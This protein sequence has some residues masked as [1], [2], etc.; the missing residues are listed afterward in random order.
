MKYKQSFALKLRNRFPIVAATATLLAVHS[1]QAIAPTNTEDDVINGQTD[2]TLDATYTGGLPGTSSDVTFTAQ[3]YNPATFT[4]PTDLSI[5]TLNDLATNSLTIQAGAGNTSTLTLNGGSNTVGADP[6]DLIYVKNNVAFTVGTTGTTNGTLKLFLANGG[7]IDIAANTTTINSVISD[8]GGGFTKTGAGTLKLTA[9]NTYTGATAINVGTLNLTGSILNSAV[10]VNT[11]ATLLFTSNN[12]ESAFV[13]GGIAGQ[14]GVTFNYGNPS[15]VFTLNEANTYTGTTTFQSRGV[16]KANVATVYS[17][18]AP[19]SGALGVNS[20]LSFVNGSSGE[21]VILNGKSQQVGALIG[22]QSGNGIVLNG[23]NL[24]IGGADESGSFSGQITGGLIPGGATG[25][26]YNGLGSSANVGGNLIKIGS[27]VQTLTNSNFYVGSTTISGG[28]LSISS[29]ADGGFAT[30][31][32]STTASGGTVLNVA[33]PTG[34]TA[35]QNVV[36]SGGIQGQKVSSVSG[37]A[38]TLNG[39]LT[40]QAANSGTAVY[41]GTGNGL[42]ISTNAASNLVLDGGT[43]QYKGTTVGSTDRLFQI[44]QSGDAGAVTATI[45]SSS[46]SSTNTLSFTNTGAVT[47]GNIGQADNL[48]LT[49]SNTGANTLA[50]SIGDNGAGAVSVAKTGVGSWTVTNTNTY[51]GGTTV[52]LGNLSTSSTGT[53]G[54]GNVAV[55]DTAGT[56]L[57]LQNTASIGSSAILS[58]GTN[59]VINMNFTGDDTLAG[60]TDTTTS[61]MITPGTYTA[62]QL[63]SFF[64][65]SSFATSNGDPTSATF[66]VVPEPGTWAMLL[67]G[68]GTL[69][70]FQRARRRKSLLA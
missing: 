48:T 16:V 1:A 24:T 32:T 35:G 37:N 43:L 25:T 17:G 30:T 10:T 68:F 51:T 57:T 9:A 39:G 55:A 66:T 13:T 40:D 41:F 53:L 3:S 20:M 26:H 69:V 47:Y 52:S 36:G 59:S 7:N 5:G 63:D 45:D 60:I 14:G 21:T 18:G 62:A 11:G 28:T 49:G 64:G 23:A 33:D 65:V 46:T 56:V 34:I 31:L 70:V 54:N 61:Q 12:N 22:G 27:G 6:A 58:F 38:V 50:P 2:L 44:G 19:V 42:G 4:V 15:S 8:N 29:I 67:G